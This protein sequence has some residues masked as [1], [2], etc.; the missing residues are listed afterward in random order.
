MTPEES[1]A[2]DAWVA[3]RMAEPWPL[4]S[5]Q[6]AVIRSALGDPPPAEGPRVA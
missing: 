3:E 1:E 2:I 6:L 4:S 5:T